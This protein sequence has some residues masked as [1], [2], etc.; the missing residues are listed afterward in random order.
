MKKAFECENDVPFTS[1]ATLAM[2]DWSHGYLAN[3]IVRKKKVQSVLV[4][5]KQKVSTFMKQKWEREKS[6]RRAEGKKYL[7]TYKQ[8][9]MT[10]EFAKQGKEKPQ[11]EKER[12]KRKKMDRQNRKQRDED[13]NILFENFFG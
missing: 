7:E 12:V 8:R 5:Q 13:M 2:H 10:K 11:A 6:E 9:L 4:N 3:H 1:L